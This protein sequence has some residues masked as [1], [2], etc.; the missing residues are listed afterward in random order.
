MFN[1]KSGE[2]FDEFL[3]RNFKESARKAAAI[4]EV[5]SEPDEKKFDYIRDLYYRMIKTGKYNA[6]GLEDEAIVM[7]RISRDQLESELNEF[8]TKEK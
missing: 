7:L 1:R 3:I 6:Y 8:K 4:P 5:V 2:T